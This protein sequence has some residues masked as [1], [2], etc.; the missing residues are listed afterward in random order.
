MGIVSG[1][2]FL[3]SVVKGENRG[4]RGNAA[5]FPEGARRI[6]RTQTEFD[7]IHGAVGVKSARDFWDRK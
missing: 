5:F 3:N 6:G 1:F 2:P 4:E 7:L